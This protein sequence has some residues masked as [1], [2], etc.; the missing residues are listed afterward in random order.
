MALHD[1]DSGVRTSAISRFGSLIGTENQD[2]AY[3]MA[4]YLYEILTSEDFEKY[5]SEYRDNASCAILKLE[6]NSNQLSSEGAWNHPDFDPIWKEFCK[7][8]KLEEK[9]VFRR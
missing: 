9:P 2:M 7:K 8:Y 5:N 3:K 4:S 6:R 1:P